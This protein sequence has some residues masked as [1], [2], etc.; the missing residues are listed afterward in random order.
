MKIGLIFPFAECL[1]IVDA[2]TF[3]RRRID[4]GQVRSLRLPVRYGITKAEG[5]ASYFNVF[6]IPYRAK[7]A[8]SYDV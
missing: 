3:A 6:M 2:T 5:I 8:W 1:R 7:M 4:L